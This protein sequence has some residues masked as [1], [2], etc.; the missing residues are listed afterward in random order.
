MC[1]VVVLPSEPVTPT[2]SRRRAGRP[3]TAAASPA[4]D[5]LRLGPGAAGALALSACG[6]GSAP[7]GRTDGFA[8][9]DCRVGSILPAAGPDAA[10]ADS[11]RKGMQLYLEQVGHRGGGRTIVVAEA[12]E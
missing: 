6:D 5:L 2:T 4:R 1:V 11:I 7:R 10:A 9:L 12:D 8:G 3:C